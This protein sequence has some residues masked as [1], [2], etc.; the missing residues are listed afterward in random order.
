[1][2]FMHAQGPIEGKEVDV[3]SPEEGFQARKGP[4]QCNESTGTITRD[5]SASKAQSEFHCKLTNQFS[6]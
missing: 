6:G 2:H 4:T 5:L 1:M 3:H